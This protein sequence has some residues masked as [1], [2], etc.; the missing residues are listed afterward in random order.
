MALTAAQRSYIM[1]RIRARDTGPEMRVRRALHCVG[2]RYR[3]H[4][5]RFPGRPDIVF[6]RRKV[7]VFVHGCFWHGHGCALAGGTPK[8]NTAFWQQKIATNRERDKRK[9]R[10]LEDLGFRVLVVWECETNEIEKL[11]D[12]LRAEIGPTTYPVS[13]SLSI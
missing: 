7:A 3:I 12:R 8:T 11:V 1:S 13:K 10:E 9:T 2:Y 4:D 6:P 5:K